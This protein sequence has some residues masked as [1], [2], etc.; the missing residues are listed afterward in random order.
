MYNLAFLNKDKW[1]WEREKER[2]R[3][4]EMIRVS[5]KEGE[6]SERDCDLKGNSCNI[7]SHLLFLHWKVVYHTFEIQS[8]LWGFKWLSHYQRYHINVVFI[9]IFEFVNPSNSQGIYNVYIHTY[10]KFSEGNVSESVILWET[11]RDSLFVSLS[12]F[13][14]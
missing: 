3:E 11:N 4:R 14:S 10:I 7:L 2:E 9:V 5:V 13:C 12:A 1:K 8:Y 6:K